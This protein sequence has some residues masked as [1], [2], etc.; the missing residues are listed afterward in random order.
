MHKYLNKNGHTNTFQRHNISEVAAG[1][2]YSVSSDGI[3]FQKT[4]ILFHPCENPSIYIDPRGKLKMLANYGSKGTWTSDSVAGGWHCIN[5]NFPLGGDCTFFFHW[6][7]YDYIIGGFTHLWSKQTTLP[8][9]TYQ[10][11]LIHI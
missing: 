3:H 7:N 10:L 1:S 9:S 2:S 4:G 8:D 5:E 6:G 11:S